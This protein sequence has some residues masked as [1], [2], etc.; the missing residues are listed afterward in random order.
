MKK[1]KHYLIELD[2]IDKTGKDTIE[3]YIA[4]LGKFK[5]IVNVRGVLSQL[6]YAELYNRN[7]DY[8]LS[9]DKNAIIVYLKAEEDD[10][11][12]RCAITHEPKIDY[13]S[14]IQAFDKAKTVL[15][16]N[17]IA[18]LEFNTTQLTPYLIAKRIIE[19]VEIL[20]NTEI[21]EEKE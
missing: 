1:L 17:G 13:N 5:Y 8:D 18:V 11:K 3:R 6:A 19:Y 15:I 10:W 21:S 9:I 2:G 7:Y 16:N 20:E 12:I 14:N 4:Y